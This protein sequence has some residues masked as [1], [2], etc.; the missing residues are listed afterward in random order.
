MRHE[1]SMPA[2]SSN[3]TPR[4][5]SMIPKTAS[6]A[7]GSSTCWRR[8]SAIPPCAAGS[9]STVGRPSTSSCSTSPGSPSTSTSRTSAASRL[10]WAHAGTDKD[11]LGLF[12]DE[13]LVLRRH[14]RVPVRV[15]THA[16]S[17]LDW[18][19]INSRVSAAL[20]SCS[21]I[22]RPADPEPPSRIVKSGTVA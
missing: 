8:W 12:L 16:S 14:P 11:V 21:R 7:P 4:S 13:V 3:S 10:V 17:L 20:A 19:P 22:D 2:Q 1:R 5:A 9:P 18:D 6:K 15:S